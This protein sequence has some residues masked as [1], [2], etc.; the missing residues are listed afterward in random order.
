MIGNDGG[1]MVFNYNL[2]QF[3]T[4]PAAAATWASHDPTG[5]FIPNALNVELDIPLASLGNPNQGRTDLRIWGV[6]LPALGQ[7]NNLTGYIIEISGGMM[8]PYDLNS[9]APHGTLLAGNVFQGFGNWEGVNQYLELVI[10]PEGIY[11]SNIANINFVWKAGT[12]ISS[13]ITAAISAAY[14]GYEIYFAIGSY[15]AQTNITSSFATLAAFAQNLQNIT[16]NKI[17]KTTGIQTQ[18]QGNAFRFWDDSI[19]AIPIALKFQDLI[20]QPTW[21]SAIEISFATVMRSDILPGTQVIFPQGIFSPYALTT[22]EAALPNAPAQTSIT[23][24]DNFRVKEVHHFGNFRQ[25]D[26]SSWRTQYTAYPV[27]PPAVA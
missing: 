17:A 24:L 21:M 25:A 18:A 15:I 2:Q 19:I 20:G 1:V 22:P 26:A 14:P 27:K 6:G 4:D 3:V 7:A 13:A 9:A 12:D 16:A 10:S 8:P 5:T 23:F 11:P